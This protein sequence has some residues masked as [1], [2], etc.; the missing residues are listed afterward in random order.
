MVPFVVKINTSIAFFIS[1]I[2]GFDYTMDYMENV[3]RNFTKKYP[4]YLVHK[5]SEDKIKV[6]LTDMVKTKVETFANTEAKNVTVTEV[7]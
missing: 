4:S 5:K 6:F 2:D 3:A 1:I 7:R